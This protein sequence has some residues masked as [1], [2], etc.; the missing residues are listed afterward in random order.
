VGSQVDQRVSCPAGTHATGGGVHVAG[1]GTADGISVASSEPFDGPDA[2]TKPDDGWLAFANNEGMVRRTMTTFAVCAAGTYT[3]H[4]HSAP[5]TGAGQ[6]GDS[7]KCP[8]DSSLT[9][10]GVHISGTGT[11]NKV[12]STYPEDGSDPDS[13]VDDEWRAYGINEIPGFTETMTVHAIC[14][15]SGSFRYVSA[16]KPLPVGAQESEQVGCPTGTSVAGGG[17]FNSG[18]GTDDVVVS[19]EPF[20][21]PDADSQPD[22][23]WRGYAANGEGSSGFVTA[24][25][26]C[27]ASGSF[28][29][30]SAKATLGSRV[31]LRVRC[32]AGTS[33]T[34]GGVHVTHAGS[35]PFVKVNSSEPFDGPDADARRD[36]GWL[37]SASNEGDPRETMTTFA[38]CATSGSYKY[39]TGTSTNIPDGTQRTAKAN[40]PGGTSVTGGGVHVGGADPEVN[41]H[42]TSPFDGPDADTR[43]DDGW[44]A[45]A[46]NETGTDA[47][48]LTY[49]VCAA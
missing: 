29:Y 27:G 11:Y 8:A 34:G 38:I 3:Y 36:D 30:V 40:C 44:L 19:S 16:F 12:N 22:D 23:G 28:S 41:V 35:S 39:V 6:E 10:G 49:A 17:V 21:G 26:I 4:T 42:S 24:Y 37:A 32:P 1:A 25:A 45:S 13:R 5:L 7:A 31:A 18:G 47:V 48:L 2:G 33:V 14:A 43:R 15:S 20:D 9:G 46:T